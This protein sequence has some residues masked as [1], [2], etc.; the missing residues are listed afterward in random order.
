MKRLLAFIVIASLVLSPTMASYAGNGNAEKAKEKPIKT[1]QIKN[2][3]SELQKLFKSELNEQKKSIAQNMAALDE[4]KIALETQYQ[5]LLA[6]GSTAEAEALLA[7]ITEL[8]AQLNGLKAEMKQVINER[9]MI[10][11]SSYTDEELAQ[12]ENVAALIEKMYADAEIL[13]LGSVTIKNNIIKLEGPAYIKGGRTII[14]VRAITEGLGATVAWNP[15]TKSVT[16]TKDGIEII[17]TMNSTQ[18]LVNGVEQQID[19]PAEITNGRT[20][21]PLRFISE[22]FGLLANWDAENGTVDIED[23]TEEDIP[24]T[25]DAA[26]DL[27]PSEQE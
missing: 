7:T 16:V 10:T 23:E 9:Y 20:Y 2:G 13:E 19:V 12:F 17:L 25:T 24:Q 11:K 22:T 1:E 5:E 14:P 4:Q 26:I 8:D 15:D 3:Q 27:P 18:V 21:V 6:A